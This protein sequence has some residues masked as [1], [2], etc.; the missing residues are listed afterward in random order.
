MEYDFLDST[1]FYPQK[2]RSL[3]ITILSIFAVII[4][5]LLILS[6]IILFQRKY[7]FNKSCLSPPAYPPNNIIVGNFNNNTFRIEWT[8]MLDVSSYTVYVGLIS[9]FARNNSI[10]VSNTYRSYAD[11]VGV[12]KGTT[13]YYYVTATN[14]CGQSV[15]STEY[16]FY[17]G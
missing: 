16:S 17:Y 15:N 13:Y 3:L 6:L 4:V 1:G 8:R 9:G 7:E 5:L 14:A 11:I 2:S 10:Y 12:P